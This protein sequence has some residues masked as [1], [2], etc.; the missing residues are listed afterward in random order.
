MQQTQRAVA[1]RRERQQPRRKN[2][3]SITAPRRRRAATSAHRHRAAEDAEQ[4]DDDDD[5][6][7][8]DDWIVDGEQS[9]AREGKE[10]V[11]AS[12]SR[13]ARPSHPAAPSRRSLRIRE[14]PGVSAFV[15]QQMLVMREER[16]KSNQQSQ[17]QQ[18]HHSECA[19]D[20]GVIELDGGDGGH[21]T[22]EA[23]ASSGASR[24]NRARTRPVRLSLSLN[25]MDGDDSDSTSTMALALDEGRGGRSSGALLPAHVDRQ[26]RSL[27]LS[28]FDGAAGG[29]SD[30]P[31]PPSP[32]PI[33]HAIDALVDGAVFT[34]SLSPLVPAARDPLRLT[35]EELEAIP[36]SS[37]LVLLSSVV[38]QQSGRECV[39]RPLLLQR[40]EALSADASA[41]TLF[42]Q[43]TDAAL[44]PPLVAAQV[45]QWREASMADC[46]RAVCAHH[47]PPLPRHPLVERQP[48]LRSHGVEALA[49][50]FPTP[51]PASLTSP[52]L[53]PL[54]LALRVE[55][56]SLTALSL[57]HIL[58]QPDAVDALV[59]AIEAVHLSFAS[60][61]L[62]RAYLQRCPQHRAV[63]LSMLPSS[64]P[65]ASAVPLSRLSTV[66]L[67]HCLASSSC[68]ARLLQAV[69]L[70]PALSR[71][72]ASHTAVDDGCLPALTFLVQ[73]C[74][75]LASLSVCCTRLTGAAPLLLR[76][77]AAAVQSAAAL[78]A[79][80]IGRCCW[81][82][83]ALAALLPSL[84][85]LS[86]LSLSH[87]H[88]SPSSLRAFLAC[89][90]RPGC[91]LRSL[92]LD[93][94]DALR[95][96]SV[97]HDL[98]Y[99]ITRGTHQRGT[100]EGMT[101]A[102]SELS[103]RGCALDGNRAARLELLQARGDFIPRSLVH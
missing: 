102:M 94:V 56:A 25:D 15:R 29:L 79:L 51:S 42:P 92:H 17:Q 71:V 22:T 72:D 60:T 21:R 20:G 19:D 103:I 30:F 16:M 57:P 38:S 67:S 49:L 8:D 43:Q 99:L 85:A 97:W 4:P 35:D 13:D 64:H 7:D 73:R 77:F 100:A 5:D 87:T 50:S 95:D 28:I 88:P 101:C 14:A 63:A 40:S 93:E 91:P 27:P 24:S 44:E 69:A 62:R 86:A 84:G 65:L 48:L 47:S 9:S 78:T 70:L 81:T 46:Y 12:Q 2:A 61:A 18:H 74:V 53:Q 66:Q 26:S 10:R 37:V 32:P 83:E 68:L 89:L 75:G 76:P 11:R 39:L 36:L 90:A 3:R 45:A 52:C 54:F 33:R 80:D 23:A 58:L 96:D 1:E 6:D 34:V 31:L 59:E 82:E 98:L 55:P 41:R